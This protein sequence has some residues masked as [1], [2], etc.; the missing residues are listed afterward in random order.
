VSVAITATDRTATGT[1]TKKYKGAWT[2]VW[3][4]NARTKLWMLD[5]ANIA[6]VK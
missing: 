6:E 1:V 3:V 2:L 5:K 4:S